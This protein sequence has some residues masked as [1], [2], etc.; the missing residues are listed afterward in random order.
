[1]ALWI[2]LNYSVFDNAVDNLSKKQKKRV[3]CGD[4]AAGFAD[5]PN[6]TVAQLEN[7]TKKL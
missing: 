1:M 7:K 4:A 2:L 6:D 5:E 3:L